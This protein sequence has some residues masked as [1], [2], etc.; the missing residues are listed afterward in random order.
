MTLAKKTMLAALMTAPLIVAGPALAD[1]DDDGERTFVPRF[2]TEA[3]GETRRGN[4]GWLA[5]FGM[6][7][8]GRDHDAE[9]GERHGRHKAGGERHWY[10]DD[11]DDDGER[12][13]VQAGEPQAPTAA[14]DNGLF[15][16]GSR[17]SVA[18]N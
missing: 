4:D 10:G 17:P 6:K 7:R 5:Y 16:K 11:D 2:G 13:G 15:K 12:A 9:H 14:P 1:S 3:R 18:I 8:H